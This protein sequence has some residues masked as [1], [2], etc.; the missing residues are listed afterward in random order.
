MSGRSLCKSLRRQQGSVDSFV[1]GGG[2]TAGIVLAAGR[3]SRFGRVKQLL[4]WGE[5]TLVGHVVDLALDSGL[6][7]VIVVTGSDAEHVAAALHGRPVR[8]VFNPDFSGGQS[9][10]IRRGIEALPQ[11]TGAVIFLLADQPGVTREVVRRL[12]QSHGETLAPIVLPTY[13]GKRG[14]PVLFDASVFG[15]LKNLAGDLG[16]RALFKGYDASIL[17]VAVDE[18]GILIDIDTPEDYL[19]ILG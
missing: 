19:R 13:Q 9:T 2:K 4:P 10:S 15:D 17:R 5:T 1:G 18:P 7:P 6:D 11:N 12:I 8:T 14:N 16:G 3:S